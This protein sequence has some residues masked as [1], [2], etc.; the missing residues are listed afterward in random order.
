MFWVDF[1]F[2]SADVSPQESR[3]ERE[4]RC[5]QS[6]HP[7]NSPCMQVCVCVHLE[8]LIRWTI[9][10]SS[11]F[12]PQICIRVLFYILS[13]CFFCLFV[14]FFVNRLLG[15]GR[16]GLIYRIWFLFLISVLLWPIK[17][18]SEQFKVGIW[19]CSTPEHQLISLLL[20]WHCFDF[21]LSP[22]VNWFILETS[23]PVFDT[24]FSLSVSPHCPGLFL[25]YTVTTDGWK[26]RI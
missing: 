19:K 6:F 23:V 8:Q 25:F 22:C 26:D 9:F 15:R 12:S 13:A 11:F 16:F 5:L 4:S 24:F 14:C 2:I 18:C 20:I 1:P 10:L 21:K 7:H 3:T 17:R